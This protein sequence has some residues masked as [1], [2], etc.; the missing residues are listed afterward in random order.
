MD[1]IEALPLSK[2]KNTIL[3]VVDKL[4]KYAH[5]N[6]MA[7]P[8]TTQDVAKVFFD[9]I[10]KLHGLPEGIISDRDKIFTSHFWQDLFK[11]MGV[12]LQMSTAYHPQLDGQ[13]ERVNRC[14]ETYLRCMCSQQP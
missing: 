2:G 8:Y 1:F 3:V 11:L 6:S 12:R 14:L 13:T 7:H 4:T 9:S 5:F 10:Y